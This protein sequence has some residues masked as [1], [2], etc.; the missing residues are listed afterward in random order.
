MLLFLHIDAGIMLIGSCIGF[1]LLLY[2]IEAFKIVKNWFDVRRI[3]K[4]EGFRIK[5]GKFYVSKS[6]NG[7]KK[8]ELVPQD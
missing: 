6:N 4:K 3:W 2:A 8:G 1:I 7:S 5:D